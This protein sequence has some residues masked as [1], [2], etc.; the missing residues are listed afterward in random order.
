[1][2][3]G[4]AE[5]VLSM[6]VNA[7]AER[8]D[9]V[10]LATRTDLKFTYE[11]NS[12]V[13]L[14]NMY[15]GIPLVENG[16]KDKVFR[17]YRRIKNIR[18]ITKSEKPDVAVSFLTDLNHDV[19]FSLLGTG[20]PLIC[21]EHTNVSHKLDLKTAVCRRIMY[22]FASAITVLTHRD[23]LIWKRRYCNVVRM[24]NPCYCHTIKT[25][26]GR[27]QS[28]LAVGGIGRWKIKGFDN[29]LRSW[30]KLCHENEDWKLKIAGGG[31]DEAFSYLKKMA[32]ELNCINIEFL[33]FRTDVFDLMKQSQLYVLSSR[34][35]GLPMALIEAMDA[36][37]CCVSFDVITG[38]SDIIRHQYNGLLAKNQDVDDLAYCL[39]RVMNNNQE[40]EL[41]ASRAAQGVLK[42]DISSVLARWDILFNKVIK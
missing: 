6:L 18:A 22:P 3:G 11:I 8:G 32:S 2:N 40:K 13:K 9:D 10:V 29:L 19:I 34:Y 31:N 35:E 33:G 21:S 37:C 39:N 24:P 1:M 16:F 36:G 42:Y 12:H 30:S 26:E 20:I 41:Y 27:E 23:Y 25:Y 15:E 7:H 28:V 4:G 14:V 17:Y 5:R 38:P